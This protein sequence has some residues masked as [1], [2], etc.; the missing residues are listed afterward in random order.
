[1]NNFKK[2]KIYGFVCLPKLHKSL[3]LLESSIAGTDTH[4]PS[5]IYFWLRFGLANTMIIKGWQCVMYM[6]G[7]FNLWYLLIELKSE[8]NTRNL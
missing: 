6:Q 5:N 7:I 2:N 3:G 8:S 4:G 1:M